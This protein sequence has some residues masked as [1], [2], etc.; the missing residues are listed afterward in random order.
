[1]EDIIKKLEIVLQQRKQMNPEDSYVSSLY[2]KGE[3][4]ICNKIIEEANELIAST[5]D[6]K[7]QIIHESADLLFHVLVLLALHDI[8]YARIIKEL[9]SRFGTSG[10]VEKNNRNK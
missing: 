3:E 2:E 7:K 10:I 9:E 8:N 4:H 1:M 5:K 6:D